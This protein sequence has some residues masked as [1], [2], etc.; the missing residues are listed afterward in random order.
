MLTRLS[1]SGMSSSDTY[2]EYDNPMAARGNLEALAEQ[3]DM[4]TALVLESDSGMVVVGDNAGLVSRF[5]PDTK[6]SV[7]LWKS[8]SFMGIENLAC[9][10]DGCYLASSDLSAKVIV[11]EMRSG[12]VTS[13][14]GQTR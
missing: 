10:R 5:H 3:A 8:V 9:S 13:G 4:V 11:Y 2:S 12:T 6:K 1:D 14:Q 7:E